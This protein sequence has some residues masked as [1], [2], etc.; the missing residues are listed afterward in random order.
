[1]IV[2]TL[3]T[4]ARIFNP[5]TKTWQIADIAVLNGRILYVGDGTSMGISA[6]KQVDCDGATVIPGM[7]DIHLH[8]ESS[9]CTPHTFSTAVLPH[10]VTTVVAEHHEMANIFGRKGIEEM[11]AASRKTALDIFHGIPSSVPSTNKNLETTG[12][13]IDSCDLPSLTGVNNPDVICLGEVMNYSTLIHE[14]D[15]LAT[16]PYAVK[17]SGMAAYLKKHHPLMAIEGHCPSVKDLDLAKLLYLGVDSDHCKQ[18]IEGMIQRFTN[19]MFVEIQEKSLTQEVVEYLQEHDVDNLWAFVTD[20]VPPDLLVKKGHLDHVVRKALRFGL[21]IEKAIIASSYSP[22][23]RMGLRDRGVLAPGKIADLI[24]LDGDPSDFSIAQVYK[25][26][27]PIEQ[28]LAKQEPH[29]FASFC[30]ESIVVNPDSDFTLL[31]Q[32]ASDNDTTVRVMKKSALS[33]YTEESFKHLEA[34]SGTLEWQNADEKLNLAVVINR[35]SAA[36]HFMQGFV[37]GDCL[38]QGAYCTTYAHDHHNILVLGDNEQDMRIALEWVLSH[39][40]GICVASRGKVACTVELPI[41]GILSTIPMDELGVQIARIQDKLRELGMRHHNPLMSLSTSTLP[42]SPALKLT[43]KGLIDVASA[44]LV[45][46][47]V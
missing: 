44:S 15:H 2:D 8:I 45:P 1:M 19:G 12:G 43:D 34:R 13:T 46:L 21:S 38:S 35:Y 4:R 7:V 10:G 22:A 23:R 40:G 18:D 24:I 41:G 36:L 9:L 39:N 29:Q 28:V 42:V 31:F 33:T 17:S 20:D 27:E 47:F 16:D 5:Y 6:D 26:G 25:R 32:V 14:F 37:S 11:I 30:N 3:F